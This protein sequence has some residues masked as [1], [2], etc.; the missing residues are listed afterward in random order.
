MAD[1]PPQAEQTDTGSGGHTMTDWLTLHQL[2]PDHCQR[3]LV[4]A[5]RHAEAE[6]FDRT[7]LR[8]A[9]CDLSGPA[10]L[11]LVAAAL[12]ASVGAP[13]SLVADVLARTDID[14]NPDPDRFPRAFT[15]HDTGQGRPYISCRYRNQIGGLLALAHEVGH[16][17]QIIAASGQ[18]QPPVVREICAFLAE[19]ALIG[20]L[21]CARPADAA[22]AVLAWRADNRVQFGKSLRALAVALGDPQSPY[23]YRWNYPLARFLAIEAQAQLAPAGLWPLFLPQATVSGL[24]SLLRI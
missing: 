8:A 5:G 22:K 3:L 6:P 12:A 11:A 1:L 16:A 9:A 4:A 10:A 14:L 18:F 7:A 20:Q 17:T 19:L 15:L 24:C 21:G 13:E 23:D 2:E